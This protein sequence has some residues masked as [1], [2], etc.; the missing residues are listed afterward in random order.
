M[1]EL[2]YTNSSSETPINFKWWNHFIDCTPSFSDENIQDLKKNVIR[3]ILGL[4]SD[5]NQKGNEEII[6]TFTG[7]NIYI[8]TRFSLQK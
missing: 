3:K 6:N 1:I 2:K 8:I 4:H 5:M 7:A